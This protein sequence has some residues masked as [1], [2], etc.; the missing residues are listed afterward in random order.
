ML[1]PDSPLPLQTGG[2][3]N[4]LTVND[5]MTHKAGF[6]AYDAN[7]NYV[8]PLTAAGIT[9][10]KLWA[11]LGNEVTSQNE[12]HIT[13]DTLEK[14]EISYPF[15]YYTV[16][17]RFNNSAPAVPV[18]SESL[19][20][21]KEPN[22]YGHFYN[23]S[24]RGKRYYTD[25]RCH[26]L[27][28][29]MV[30]LTTCR[31]YSD[32]ISERFPGCRA[33]YDVNL[34]QTS[35]EQVTATDAFTNK[36]TFASRYWKP[37]GA[38]LPWIMNIDML[39]TN[40]TGMSHPTVVAHDP[41][42][43][44]CNAQ[45]LHSIARAMRQHENTLTADCG[46][47]VERGSTDNIYCRDVKLSDGPLGP[48][49]HKGGRGFSQIIYVRDHQLTVSYFIG[50]ER[51][52]DTT[53]VEPIFYDQDFLYTNLDLIQGCLSGKSSCTELDNKLLTVMQNYYAFGDTT[54]F[55]RSSAYRFTFE[56]GAG[57]AHS[58]YNGNNHLDSTV[59]FTKET[60][61]AIASISKTAATIMA[62]ENNLVDKSLAELCKPN[63][64]A[65]KCG[66]TTSSS[67]NGMWVGIAVGGA[68]L[69][70]AAV[71]YLSVGREQHYTNPTA[72]EDDAKEDED[73][74]EVYSLSPLRF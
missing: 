28:A 17:H 19:Y 1:I 60:Y 53:Y 43:I 69:L 2:Y 63:V 4:G 59:P 36:A 67:N 54:K 23:Q 51:G 74:Q 26:A 25:T 66:S 47:I 29:A 61:V 71:S 44:Y 3:C 20:N 14:L 48:V 57:N 16:R 32:L 56:D 11:E 15:V 40:Y 31:S 30:E 24:R 27:T 22:Y 21:P 62:L 49:V 35:W 7:P 37:F 12:L 39:E 72:E 33:R 50:S 9:A 8:S 18:F 65:Q 73:D 70:L 58:V 38:A 13:K 5:L 6:M 52:R 42:S 68:V 45:G 55:Y 41:N 10:D 46:A 64:Y 34:K